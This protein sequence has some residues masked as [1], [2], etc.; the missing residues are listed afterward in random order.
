[1]RLTAHL[2]VAPDTDGGHLQRAGT[3][4]FRCPHDLVRLRA[5]RRRLLSHD[6]PLP[7]PR[8][9]R[10]A[11]GHDLNNLFDVQAQVCRWLGPTNRGFCNG[12][13]CARRMWLCQ[14]RLHGCT[15]VKNRHVLRHAVESHLCRHH[16]NRPERLSHRL[17]SRHRGGLAQGGTG[18]GGGYDGLGA[19]DRD[20]PVPWRPWPR[21]G[22][23]R[24]LRAHGLSPVTRHLTSAASHGTRIHYNSVAVQGPIHAGVHGREERLGKAERLCVALRTL[25]T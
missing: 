11:H 13:C 8:S 4:G 23:H 18:L 15:R 1:M 16:G 25:H 24:E 21:D 6:V 20:D 9:P 3:A 12:F 22:L 17:L 14:L 5:G 19:H 2:S 7:V 10:A